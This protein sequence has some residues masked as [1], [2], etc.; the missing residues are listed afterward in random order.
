MSIQLWAN[1]LQRT[2]ADTGLSAGKLR[3]GKL[4]AGKLRA[5][6]LRA[7]KLRAGKLRA[8]KLRAGG[9]CMPLWRQ[10]RAAPRRAALRHAAPRTTAQPFRKT[11]PRPDIARSVS[12]SDEPSSRSVRRRRTAAFS[13]NSRRVQS[14]RAAAR[15]GRVG[16]SVKGGMHA[17]DEDGW[18]G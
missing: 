14:T 6:K 11:Q 16:E 18:G 10:G 3:A 13:L 1:R 12:I 5:R 7:G 8:G 4:R 15:G 9:A 2:L 17:G